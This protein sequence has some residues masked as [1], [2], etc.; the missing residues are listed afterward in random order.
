MRMRLVAQVAALMAATV[1][2]TL[3]GWQVIGESDSSTVSVT[4][5]AEAPAEDGSA[6]DEPAEMEQPADPRTLEQ[7]G[8]NTAVGDDEGADLPTAHPPGATG[9]PAD[10]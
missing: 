6:A 2:L 5:I 4:T 10:D 8:R 3:T 9:T 7:T 1:A